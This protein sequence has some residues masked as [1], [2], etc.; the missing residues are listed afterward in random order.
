MLWQHQ[1]YHYLV[2]GFI[3]FG[4]SLLFLEASISLERLAGTWDS[5]WYQL[6]DLPFRVENIK[7]LTNCHIFTI[8]I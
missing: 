8:K 2:V 1:A 7:S 6:F 4:W 5:D 3:I